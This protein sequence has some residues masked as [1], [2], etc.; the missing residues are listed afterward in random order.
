[1]IGTGT[2]AMFTVG[3]LFPGAVNGAR[4]AG[5]VTGVEK[6]GRRGWGL[7]LSL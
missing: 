7:G 6:E 3:V 4:I 2:A 1:V 5:R